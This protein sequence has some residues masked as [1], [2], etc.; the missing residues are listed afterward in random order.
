GTPRRSHADALRL[1]SGL[2]DGICRLRYDAE[3]PEAGLTAGWGEPL[4]P[5]A[6][7]GARTGRVVR[8]A[9]HD[10]RWQAN[11]RPQSGPPQRLRDGRYQHARPLDGPGYRPVDRR[12]GR[13]H[14]ASY[15]PG[16]VPPGHGSMSAT[17]P[18]LPQRNGMR[19]TEPAQV[20]ARAPPEQ[21]AQG[22]AQQ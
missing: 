7:Y 21:A 3:S 12:P 18:T 8:L 10:T 1:P 15:R 17:G 16:S 11:Y 5:G 6:L 4:S 22:R 19:L 13:R 20:A 9:T 2:D 14:H